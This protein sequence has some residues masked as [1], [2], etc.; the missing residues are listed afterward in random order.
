MP[1]CLKTAMLLLFCL[2]GTITFAEPGGDKLG[3]VIQINTQFHSFVGKPT[4]LLIIRDLDNNNVLPYLYDIKSGNNY[5][6][7]L[8]HGHYYL[9]T[10]SEMRFNPYRA[11]TKNFCNLESNGKILRG[12]SLYI[13][14]SGN[15]TSHDDTYTCNVTRFVDPNFTVATPT[16]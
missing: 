3:Q 4:W 5:W 1:N 2:C 12:E 10:A 14:I 15:L 9:I 11:K 7:A 6:I 16:N 13:N 8:T